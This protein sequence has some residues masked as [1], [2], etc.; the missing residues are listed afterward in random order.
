MTEQMKT[1]LKLILVMLFWG[2]TFVS[3]RILAQSYHPYT[4]SFM[5][6]FIAICFLIPILAINKNEDFKL[7]G[8]QIFKVIILGLTGIFAY[9]YFYFGGLKSTEAGKASL[10]IATNPAITTTIAGLFLGE[11]LRIKKVFGALLALIGALVVISEGYLANI[12]HGGF[13]KGEILLFG[14]V[15]SWV[16]YTLFGKVSLKKL[17]PLKATT[18]AC[19]LGTIFLFPFAYQHGLGSAIRQLSLSQFLHLFY[20][21]FFATVLGFIWFYQ[22]I[23]EIGASKAAIFINLVPI[24]GVLAGFFFLNESVKVSLLIGGL[25]VMTGVTLVQK[26]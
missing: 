15:C 6:F 4:I 26:S 10:I 25:I 14:A 13:Q 9:N 12:I 3:G 5:R 21:G 2:A 8:H 11:G 19:L 16:A 23:K 17:S 7:E 1:V 18:Y 22:G 24:F 20:L